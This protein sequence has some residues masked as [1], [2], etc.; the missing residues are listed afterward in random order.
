MK[1]FKYIFIFVFLFI[2]FTGNGQVS[3][4][5]NLTI[6]V[7]PSD[8]KPGESVTLTAENFSF[9]INQSYFT[10]YVD[11]SVVKD[12]LGEESLT[13]TVGKSNDRSIIT[14]TVNT[15]DSLFIEE[16]I[17]IQP[18]DITLLWQANTNVPT[19]Y[20]GKALHTPGSNIKFVAIANVY[21]N[22][23]RVPS[24]NLVYT[25]KNDKKILGSLSGI[26][27][28]SITLENKGILRDLIVSV[29]VS[30]VDDLISGRDTVVV[31]VNNPEVFFYENDPLIGKRYERGLEGNFILTKDEVTV[32]AEPFFFSP[33]K[34]SYSWKVDGQPAGTSNNI[35]IRSSEEDVSLSNVSIEVKHPD[36]FLQSVKKAFGIE[37]NVPLLES[38]FNF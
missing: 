34:L 6:S 10:W 4:F 28:N 11:G 12:G 20:K 21:Q 26:G 14:L 35:L 37:F 22:R 33:G 18:V 23:V 32:S 9:D 16:Q 19:F 24:R 5:N 30:T 29:S 15:D 38:L 3:Y 1:M 13:F 25:W 27:K 31:N 36:Y 17:T 7:S 8:P 2:P